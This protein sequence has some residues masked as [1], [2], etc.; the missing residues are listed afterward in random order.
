MRHALVAYRPFWGSLTQLSDFHYQRLSSSHFKFL[1]YKTDN[2]L[3]FLNCQYIFSIFL[4]F[5]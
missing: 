2:N 3:S 5:Y 4:K 1:V